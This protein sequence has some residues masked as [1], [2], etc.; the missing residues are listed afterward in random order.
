MRTDDSFEL[1]FTQVLTP[2]RGSGHKRKMKS[3]HS[4]PETFKRIKQS[5]ITIKNKDDLCCASAMMTAKA[6]VDQHFSWEGFKKGRRTQLQQAQLLHHKAD[7]SSGLCGYLSLYDYQLVLVDEKRGYDV[8]RFS[9]PQD[10]QLVLLYSSHHYV[11]ITSL[12]GF[13]AT[14]YFC[15]RCLKP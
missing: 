14:S 12:P 1:S 15:Y 11:V 2:P 5:V 10:K 3:G 7:V 13:F 9:L 8:S 6:K 4:H